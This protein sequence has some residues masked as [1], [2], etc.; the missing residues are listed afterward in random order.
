[1]KLTTKSW[2]WCSLKE[3]T[4]VLALYLSSWFV[5]NTWMKRMQIINWKKINFMGVGAFE[6]KLI[7]FKFPNIRWCH[8]KSSHTE[9]LS[10]FNWIPPPTSIAPVRNTRG[11]TPLKKINATHEQINHKTFD[12]QDMAWLQWSPSISMYF[13]TG[14]TGLYVPHSHAKCLPPAEQ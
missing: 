11:Q 5:H 3:Y 10:P 1:M 8:K 14:H 7:D 2:L 9:I 4:P 13:D 6:L 12:V